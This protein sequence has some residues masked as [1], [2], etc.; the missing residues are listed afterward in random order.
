[1]GVTWITKIARISLTV[2]EARRVVFDDANVGKPEDPHD[3][4]ATWEIVT[5]IAEMSIRPADADEFMDMLRDR[6]LWGLQPNRRGWRT[7]EGSQNLRPLPCSM[8][9][10]L[11]APAYR[12]QTAV[13]SWSLRDFRFPASPSD[14]S[15]YEGYSEADHRGRPSGRRET[16]GHEERSQQKRCTDE[17]EDD[18]DALRN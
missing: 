14:D 11:A 3:I 17:R 18:C 7:R 13:K 5:D 4:R 8:Y 9:V 2:S 1:M 10:P 16:D 12:H 6:H 15:A